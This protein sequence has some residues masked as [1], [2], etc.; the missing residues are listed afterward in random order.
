MYGRDRC[1]IIYVALLL[2]VTSV[3]PAI[4]ISNS[5]VVGSNN[6]LVMNSRISNAMN[7]GTASLNENTVAFC[8]KIENNHVYIGGS[9]YQGTDWNTY[10]C[11]MDI[12]NGTPVLNWE[13][14]FDYGGNDSI[15]GLVYNS[16]KI[17][18]V[19]YSTHG[20]NRQLLFKYDSTTGSLDTYKV[21]GSDSNPEV[22]TAISY[23]DGYI[24]TTGSQK[25][26]DGLYRVIID[27]YSTNLDN[28]WS[29]ILGPFTG[30]PEYGYDL[31]IANGYAYVTGV[32]NYYYQEWELYP[33]LVK[34]DITSEN[35]VWSNVYGVVWWSQEFT[36]CLYDGNRVYVVGTD[37]G[38]QPSYALYLSWIRESDGWMDG[39]VDRMWGG[40][41]TD[42]GG[43][44]IIKYGS[45]LFVTGYTKS[46]GAGKADALLLK[47]DTSFNEIWHRT[48]GGSEVDEA[49]GVCEYN[50]Y[51]FTVG[52]T[53]SYNPG[54]RS[55]I[56]LKYSPGDGT[57]VWEHVWR[58]GDLPP[59]NNPPDRPSRPQGETNGKIGVEYNYSTVCADPDG[60]SIYYW[61]DWS[62]G[63]NS[64]WI[65]PFA[66]GA[67]AS[68]KHTW[69]AKGAYVIKVKA[70]DTYGLESD[71]SDTLPVVMP[72]IRIRTSILILE[73]LLNFL[74]NLKYF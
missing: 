6:D 25:N 39:T 38:A 43:S 47:V 64:G 33:F 3:F 2:V 51:I 41:N 72:K 74:S 27:K 35:E 57:L 29:H 13:K 26:N 8:L 70:K 71:W 45:C 14:T 31:D 44:G 62:D 19:G 10:I 17:Y 48:W 42:D 60:D 56:L 36:S 73:R 9:T 24:Y 23:Y 12:S 67:T 5:K 40:Y 65:G 55:A 53:D 63:T 50:G 32:C 11:M 54:S 61:W 59:Q 16:G 66:S 37:M 1:I 7:D 58:G 46:Y 18:A 20:G 69:T 68:A 22:G 52:Y 15:L 34:F 21:L 28:V 4:G 49:F 30:G